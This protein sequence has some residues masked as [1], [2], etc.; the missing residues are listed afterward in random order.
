VTLP[1]LLLLVWVLASQIQR[2][3]LDARNTAL[4]IARATAAEMLALHEQSLQLLARMAERPRIRDFDGTTCDSLFASVEF[5]PEFPDLLLFDRTGKLVCSGRPEANEAAF[6]R[7]TQEWVASELRAGRLRPGRPIIRSIHRRWVSVLAKDLTASNGAPAGTLVLVE[8]PEIVGDEALPGSAIVT[9]I[10]DRGIILAR[11]DHS[12]RWTGRDVGSGGVAAVALHQAQGR[13]E[14]IGV[15][16]VQRQYGF[17][18]LPAMGWHLYVG[19][20]SSLVM[21]PVRNLMV[22]G[23]TGAALVLVVVIL[24]ASAFARQI[25]RPINAASRAAYQMARGWYGTISDVEGP[26]EMVTMA[27]AFNEMV[28][29]RASA[30]Q[31]MQESERNLKALSDRLLSVQ[32][33]E[34][35]RIAREIHD[36]LG[37]S[38]TALKMDV[39]GLLEEHGP[40][41]LRKRILSTLDSTVTAVQRIA[42][43][44]RPSVLDDLGVVAAIESEARLFEE[45]TGIECELSLPE[46]LDVDSDIA[47]VIYRIFQE[48]VTN[49]SRH[50][51]AG[52]IEV[53]LRDREDEL[54]LEIRDDGRGV[55]EA[56]IGDPA[57]LGLIGMRERAHLAGGIL[58]VAGIDGRGTIV[59]VRIPLPGAVVRIPG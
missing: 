38:L 26:R 49:V 5:V 37:Q 30:E 27:T 31:Q 55:T 6:A 20:P 19:V 41:S 14:A 23:V 28:E 34:R 59:S 40:T 33:Q 57:S 58:T 56:E 16:G 50:S 46:T 9:I 24:L 36:D 11:S 54:L 18:A 3:E 15:D 48:A 21:Q 47:T 7:A 29:T 35:T 32:E 53:R 51:N 25:A 52:R 44:L 8:L 45:R 4:R 42:S 12:E 22:R 17:T 10:D 1:P 13:V 39:I 2:E 43:E